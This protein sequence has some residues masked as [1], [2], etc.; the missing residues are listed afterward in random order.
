MRNLILSMM[1]LGAG[2]LAAVADDSPN[3]VIE[4][5]VSLLA[6]QLDGRKDELA[7]DRQALTPVDPGVGSPGL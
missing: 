2:A 7:A 6:E 3:A 1:F 4:E 5:S